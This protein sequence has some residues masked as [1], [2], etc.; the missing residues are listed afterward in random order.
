[1]VFF[2]AVHVHVHEVV[3]N[4]LVNDLQRLLCKNKCLLD[5]WLMAPA[6]C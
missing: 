5:G 3:I 2:T 4:L 1:M 6:G